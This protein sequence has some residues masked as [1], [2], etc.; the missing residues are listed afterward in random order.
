VPAEPGDSSHV[1]DHSVDPDRFFDEFPRFVET[2]E[3]GPWLLRLNARYL[4]LIHANRELIRGSRVLDLASHDGRFSFAALHAGAAR[5]VGIEHDPRL[6]QKAEENLA[7]YDVPRRD[8]EFV[9]G[10]MFD[11]IRTVESC[12]V[13]FCFGILYHIN[14]HMRLLSELAELDARTIIFDTNVSL[15]ES[16][17]IELRSPLKGSPPPV[18]SQLEGWPSRAALEAMWTS[19][20][21][22]FD[23]F[24]WPG[25]GLADHAKLGDYAAG[26]RLTAV[27]TTNTGDVPFDVRAAAVREVRERQ[28]DLPTQWLT[29]TEVASRYDMTPQALRVWVRRADRELGSRDAPPA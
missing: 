21:W 20:G 12:D 10:D 2:S 18:G 1:T 27:V 11:H 7:F 9:A 13:V 8:Y 23:Y 28:R 29:I 4:A 5:V 22:T 3:T 6:V 17:V 16:A 25:S 26:R 24:D 15:M 19:L 14:E